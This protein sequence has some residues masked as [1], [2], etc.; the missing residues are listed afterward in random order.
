MCGEQQPE[1]EN[2]SQSNGNDGFKFIITLIA[3]LLTFSYA[4][5]NHL[6]NTFVDNTTG[7]LIA[8]LLWCLA[9]LLVAF[10]VLYVVIKGYSME[11]QNPERKKDLTRL[12]SCIYLFSFP[13]I[14]VFLVCGLCLFLLSYCFKIKIIYTIIVIVPIAFSL[15]LYL[16]YR[17]F[18]DVC[19]KRGELWCVVYLFAI[20]LSTL[21]VPSLIPAIGH[22]TVDIGDVCYKNNV[23]IPVL[24][25]VTGREIELNISIYG[26]GHDHIFVLVDCM[27]LK[28]YDIFYRNSSKEGYMVGNALGHGKFTVFINTT[29]LTTGYYVLTCKHREDGDLC[30][31]G[32]YLLNNSQQLCVE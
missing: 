4:L 21:A 29:N 8:A 1:N 22:V 10:L 16:K 23:P 7:Y 14:L 31:K 26:G 9:Y 27:E 2:P 6:Q 28:Q 5:Y 30:S 13:L 3:A 15:I 11:V 32:F 17:F 24:I 18:R 12:A 20:L 25:Q 19:G